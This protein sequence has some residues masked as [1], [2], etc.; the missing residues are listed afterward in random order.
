MSSILAAMSEYKAPETASPA[1]APQSQTHGLLSL[2]FNVL[3]P[4]LI[5]H[6]L[7]AR[8][9]A[10]P[11][12]ILALAFPLGFGI[13]DFLKLKKLNPLSA[14]GFI[15]VSVTGTLAV[16]GLGGMWFSLKEA[17]FPLL[18]GIF[19][20]ISAYSKNPFIKTL[21][22]N[23]Q[24]LYLDKILAALD[25]RQKHAEFDR[26]LRSSTLLLSGSF[27][28]SAVL[29]FFLSIRIF[30]ELDPG[31]SA[32]QKSLLLNSQIAEMT[33]WAFLVIMI[34]SMIFLVAILWYLMRGIRQLTGLKMD[35]ILR[36]S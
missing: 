21:L 32:E 12:L 7:S 9:G 13:Y 19:V 1:P 14:L 2:F 30:T 3:I 34:P 17:F 35:E 25:E 22:L 20:I 6:K 36:Q 4:V 26:H 31:L 10:L 23:P 11:T 5:L 33:Q 8:L 27:F 18:I 24:V 29:N 15:N 16:L 28:L